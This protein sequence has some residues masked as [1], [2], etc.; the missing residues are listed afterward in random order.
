VK[1]LPVIR[2]NKD[3]AC[4]FQ[5]TQLEKLYETGGTVFYL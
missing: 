2:T 1:I 3:P 4:N 5:T